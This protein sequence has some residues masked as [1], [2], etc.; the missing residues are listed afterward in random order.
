MP[1]RW[2]YRPS[3]AQVWLAD[4]RQVVRT[5]GVLVTAALMVYLI[6]GSLA[7][8]LPWYAYGQLVIYG[9]FTVVLGWLTPRDVDTWRAKQPL[10]AE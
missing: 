4:H 6:V 5:I 7:D 9:S 8:P 1:D 3:T 10:K 2:T